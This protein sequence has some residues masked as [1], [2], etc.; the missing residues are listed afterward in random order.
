MPHEDANRI[1]EVWITALPAACGAVLGWVGHNL[2]KDDPNMNTK[3]FA[4]GVMLAAFT[5][6]C[7]CLLL[8]NMGFPSPM[9]SVI[10]SAIGSSGIKGYEWLVQKSQDRGDKP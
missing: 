10:A 9:A 8:E 5:G 4:G 6:G 1:F 2:V 7:V 3:K